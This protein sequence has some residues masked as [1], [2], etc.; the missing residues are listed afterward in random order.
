MPNRK[1]DCMLRC[2]LSRVKITPEFPVSLAGFCFG[3]S[4][5]VLTDLYA[6]IL[7]LEQVGERTALLAVDLCG[8][9]AAEVEKIRT[10]LK[11]TFDI[12]NVLVN[13]SHTHSGPTTFPIRG[14][15]G[16]VQPEYM[17]FL[18][19]S[20]IEGARQATNDMFT[21]TVAA[22]STI[23]DYLTYCP[24]HRNARGQIDPELG[25]VAIH[26]SQ[27]NL[28]GLLTKFA[29]HAVCL[30]GYRNMI[31]ADFPGYLRDALAR[32]LG[33]GVTVMYLQGA[34][35][36]IMPKA[37]KG[38]GH[39]EPAVGRQ[40][41]EALAR[42]TIQ[43]L[44]SA[45][46]S[47]DVALHVRSRTIRLPYDPLPSSDALHLEVT[48]L[49]A[50]LDSGKLPAQATDNHRADI[51][52]ALEAI[53]IQKKDRVQEDLEAELQG[54]VLGDTVLLAVP[55]ELYAEIGMKIKKNSPFKHTFVLGLS[56]GAY[57]YLAT[58]N[59]YD[60]KTYTTNHACRRMG[61]WSFAR[62]VS[63]VLVSEALDLLTELRNDSPRE[64]IP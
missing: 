50:E 13:A 35:G 57:G 36:D 7:I 11:D 22:N 15:W 44:Q 52:W 59:A 21:A 43:A 49:Q 29:C 48:R 12:N 4:Q 56:N 32:D 23:V 54:L 55:F 25:V 34:Q 18:H 8:L 3:E 5:G 63:D 6:G 31:S 24:D 51:E 1:I 30:H 46:A 45:P 17:Q 19:D 47:Q 40:V 41:G 20:I 27:G 39:G 33:P 58:P 38:A 14:G 60:E 2:G 53:E 9:A 42:E 10:D 62:N 64:N 16:K 26:D 28:R 37:F 61:I